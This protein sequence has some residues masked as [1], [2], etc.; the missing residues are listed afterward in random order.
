M[1]AL[2]RGGSSAL[3]L[4][5]LSA[6]RQKFVEQKRG[7]TDYLSGKRVDP[8]VV[9]EGK[10][11]EKPNKI[12]IMVRQMEEEGRKQRGGGGGGGAGQE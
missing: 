2:S 10:T 1:G 6:Y 3:Y 9:E 12:K 4:Q 7:I 11:L 5:E 8:R